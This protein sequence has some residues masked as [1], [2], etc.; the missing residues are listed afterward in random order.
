MILL[1]Y[2]NNHYAS[3]RSDGVGDLFDFEGLK[4][5]EI[6]QH[7][8]TTTEIRN[9]KEYQKRIQSE[10]ENL[11]QLDPNL[12]QAIEES[13]AIEEV[14]NAY[15]RFYALRLKNKSNQQN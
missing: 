10:K 5:R 15:L 2:R 12:R 6:E 4:P 7:L 9:S 11:C 14:H 1:F 13:I 3:I 8:V